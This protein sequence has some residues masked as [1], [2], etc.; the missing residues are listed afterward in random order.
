MFQRNNPGEDII[1]GLIDGRGS[2]FKVGLIKMW[3]KKHLSGQFI[4]Y[5][6]IIGEYKPS[7]SPVAV[8]ISKVCRRFEN[9]IIGSST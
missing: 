8:L 1:Y 6:Y 5:F 4:L 9:L 2:G 3:L 7:M